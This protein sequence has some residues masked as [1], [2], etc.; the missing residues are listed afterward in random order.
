MADE[1]ADGFNITQLATEDSCPP[2]HPSTSRLIVKG[3]YL[4]PRT[5]E[6]A[7][8]GDWGIEPHGFEPWSSQTNDIKFDTCH[9]LAR[10]SALLGDGKDQLVWCQDNMTE[11]DIRSWCWWL[12]LSM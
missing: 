1:D 7:L 3:V 4:A 12:G 5:D 11:W 8:L 2:S 9:F 10:H 6:K